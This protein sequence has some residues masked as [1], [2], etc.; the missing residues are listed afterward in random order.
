MKQ[1]MRFVLCFVF[2][3]GFALAEDKKV[4]TGDAKTDAAIVD[5]QSKRGGTSQC[6][7][8]LLTVYKV[9]DQ[10]IEEVSDA[11][12]K[13]PG[14]IF[15]GV[16]NA[17]KWVPSMVSDAGILWTYDAEEKIVTKFNR[18]R[19]YRETELEVDAYVPD[20]LRPF[21]GVV[22][23]SIRLKSTSDKDI[24]LFEAQLKP[25]LLNAQL[26]VA[27][28]NA[29]VVVSKKDGLLRTV[30]AFDAEG[31]DVVT[32]RFENIEPAAK[33]P[34]KMFE[35]VIPAG[36]HIIDGTEDAVQLLKSLLTTE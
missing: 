30:T 4:S 1:L 27:L 16:P 22:W 21:R 28:V 13:G 14:F 12:F 3:N 35:F 17:G 7:A 15:L 11:F 2:M 26:P 23:E 10:E 36:A 34:N 20:L 6:Q 9:M 31:N 24:Y 33:I 18:G 5:V 19:I 25:N 8:R 29:Q 32:R